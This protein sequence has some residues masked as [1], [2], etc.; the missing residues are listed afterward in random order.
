M[1]YQVIARKWRPQTFDDIVGQ[2]HLTTSLKNA[3]VTGRIGHAYLFTGIRGVGKTT[4]ARVFAKAL[5]CIEGPTATPCNVCAACTEVVRGTAMDVKEIDGASN[6][7]IDSIRELREGVAFAPARDRYKIYIIDEVHML[8]GEAF[9]ALLKTLE[10]PPAHCIFVFATTEL[11]KVPATIASRCQVF[12]FKRVSIPTLVERMQRIAAADGIEATEDALR[13]IAREADGS[14]RDALSLMDQVISFSGGT[15]R[16]ADVADILRTGNR[17]AHAR[18]LSAILAEN[19]GD[20]VR[21][22]QESMDRGM[23][24]RQFLK[25]LANF[26]GEGIRIRVLGKQSGIETGLTEAEIAESLSLMEKHSVDALAVLLGLLTHASDQ[27]AD[28]R[29][30]EL[31]ALS[32]LVRASR[33]SALTGLDEIVGRLEEMGRGDTAM[34]PPARPVRQAEP[35]VPVK[36]PF[37]SQPPAP[38]KPLVPV[39]PPAPVEAPVPV[40]RSVPVDMPTPTAPLA[41]VE[42]ASPAVDADRGTDRL[43]RHPTMDR[44]L[45]VF[46]GEIMYIKNE[47]GR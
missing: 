29:S 41:P 27:A 39:Q 8:T 45:S 26:L 35:P 11:H 38:V 31:V 42:A 25:D 2:E 5:N 6:R 7:G 16:E 47:D 24:P 15:V 12:E 3:I 28:S 32:A 20:A 44:V 30:P 17:S 19:P 34:A 4:A 43:R 46:G 23:Q 40:P 18:A 21:S 33:L 1:S 14:V 36:P 9:N 13:L 10:E 22:L 37:P